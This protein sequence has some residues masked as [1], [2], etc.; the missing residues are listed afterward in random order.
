MDNKT[1]EANFISAVVYVH[2][3][4]KNIRL[5]LSYLDHMLYDNFKKYEIIC[6][7]DASTDESIEQMRSY[8]NSEA[9]GTVTLLHMSYF[10]GL[11]LAMNAGM[12]L[13]IGDFVFEFDSICMD[14][15]SEL[16]MEAYA[17][18]LK[19][20]DIVSAVADR[21]NGWTS[22]TFYKVFNHYSRTQHKLQNET[23]RIL[24]RRA[25]N[26]VH[27]LSRTIPYRKALYAN[28]GLEIDAIRYKENESIKRNF[29][30]EQ[31][32]MRRTLAV[33]SL[34]LFTNIA[35]KAARTMTG[36][37]M[38]AAI[39]AAIYAVVIFVCGNPIAGWTTTIL[40]VSFSFF[41]LFLILTIVI[42]YLSLIVELIFRKQKYSFSSIEKITK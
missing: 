32:K 35:Y 15:D 33:D 36:I 28:C 34:I 30:R 6:V 5:F 4:E 13:T 14:Y 8:A 40:F 2:N 24:S 10:Q 22:D 37:M 21:K 18:S 39:V 9:M 7:E 20:C 11:E 27:S 25:I 1:K 3:E 17:R 29:S 38:L 16:P 23:F 12:D 31:E 41:G 42:K 26:R 19:G